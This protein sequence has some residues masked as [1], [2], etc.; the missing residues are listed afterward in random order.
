MAKSK[1][2]LGAKG[3][4]TIPAP[5]RAAL[6]LKPGARLEWRLTPEGD[7]L[8]RAVQWDDYEDRLQS[9]PRAV[10]VNLDGL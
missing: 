2:T 8:V 3:Q 1:S 6:G 10:K 5:V 4:T 7:V 9:V